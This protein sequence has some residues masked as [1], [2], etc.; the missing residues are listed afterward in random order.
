MKGGK[1]K[2]GVLRG[3][4]SFTPEGVEARK[5]DLLYATLDAI[6]A[7]GLDKATVREIAKRAG[8][9]P[10]L[11]RH[12]F[13]SKELMIQAAYRGVSDIMFES[14]LAVAE[15]A[16]PDAK[17]RLLAYVMA[18]FRPPITD[19]RNLTLWATFISRLS[20]D[21]A[22]AGIHRDA[23]TEARQRLEDYIVAALRQ[24][25]R[26]PSSDEARMLSISV[27]ALIDGLWLEGTMAPDLFDEG[28][29]ARAAVSSVERLLNISF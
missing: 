3:R 14:A 26:T 18:S 2:N 28:E 10:G 5:K 17:A 20:V 4:R 7:R 9:T 15:A 21:Q 16:G 25:G 23:Y 27:N 22:L 1:A 13:V 24:E 6:A 8:V 12:Y 19:P 11:I 29:L